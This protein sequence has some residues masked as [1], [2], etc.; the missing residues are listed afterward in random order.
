MP[1]PVRVIVKAMVAK[2]KYAGNEEELK[3]A[4]RAALSKWKNGGIESVEG[5]TVGSYV[6]G[7]EIASALTLEIPEIRIR[8]VKLVRDPVVGTAVDDYIYVDKVPIMEWEL[9]VIDETEALFDV[10]SND[11]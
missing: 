8:D 6:Y 9:A 2:N 3:D 5:L 11:V 4:M 7:D 10:S 1:I